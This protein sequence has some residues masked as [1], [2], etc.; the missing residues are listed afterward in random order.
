MLGEQMEVLPALLEVTM[1]RR[2][3]EAAHGPLGVDATRRAREPVLTEVGADHDGAHATRFA[4]HDAERVRL[5]PARASRAPRLHADAIGVRAQEV[6]H[7]L[8]AHERPLPWIAEEVRLADR[9]LHQCRCERLGI[10]RD[11]V[12]EGVR[13]GHSR[14]CHGAA[15]RGLRDLAP[16]VGKREPGALGGEPYDPRIRGMAPAD[17]ERGHLRRGDHGVTG[18]AARRRASASSSAAASTSSTS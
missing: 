11:R 10:R 17:R 9:E 2:V 15:D 13:V 14:M 7:D 1:P 12:G 16:R 5:F 3:V 4:Q 6:G 18:A 8:L